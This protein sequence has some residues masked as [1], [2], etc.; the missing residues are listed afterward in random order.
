MTP[1]GISQ[2]HYHKFIEII[3]FVAAGLAYIILSKYAFPFSKFKKDTIFQNTVV[4]ESN[5]REGIHN[6]I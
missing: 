4:L 2:I 1:K 3:G 6:E 5:H